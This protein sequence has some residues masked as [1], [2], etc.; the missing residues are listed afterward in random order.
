[1]RWPFFVA[2]VII[3]LATKLIS[4][5]HEVMHALLATVQGQQVTSMSMDQTWIVGMN[6]ATLLGAYFVELVLYL[7]IAIKARPSRLSWF[8]FGVAHALVIQAPMS[9]DF[10][11]SPGAIGAFILLWICGIAFGWYR[12]MGEVRVSPQ[13]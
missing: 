6:D 9:T 7:V 10:Q 3:R 2:A 4:P 1:M 12:L 5:V 8:C 11:Y 13:P